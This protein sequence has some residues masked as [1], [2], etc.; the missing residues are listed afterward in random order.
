MVNSGQFN[1]LN[2]EEGITATTRFLESKGWGKKTVTY[3][4]RDW[5]ISR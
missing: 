5:L 1:G 3:K 2:S 4:M